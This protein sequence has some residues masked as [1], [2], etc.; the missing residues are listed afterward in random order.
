MN[1]SQSVKNTDDPYLKTRVHLDVRHDPLRS[2]SHRRVD[3]ELSLGV[4]GMTRGMKPGGKPGTEGGITPPG[5]GPG[6]TPGIGPSPPPRKPG[7]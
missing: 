6:R 4:P 3:Y 1:R 7:G 5:I 2:A